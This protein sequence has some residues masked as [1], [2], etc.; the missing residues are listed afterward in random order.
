MV[1]S[2]P[3]PHFHFFPSTL[4]H[5]HPPPWS[6]MHITQLASEYMRSISFP[7]SLSTLPW[8]TS[9]PLPQE[10]GH[11]PLHSLTSWCSHT[12]TSLRTA[13]ALSASN[14]RGEPATWLFLFQIHKLNTIISPTRSKSLWQEHKV[15][16][17]HIHGCHLLTYEQQLPSLVLSHCHYSLAVYAHLIVL[18]TFGIP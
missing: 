13:G 4:L 18:I 8:S 16:I 15:P 10:Q 6:H 2:L 3:P 5:L 14:T 1:N 7:H 9:S 17:T 11:A 12:T